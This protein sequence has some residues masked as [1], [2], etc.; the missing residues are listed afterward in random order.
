MSKSVLPKKLITS[1]PPSDNEQ[2]APSTLHERVTIN[3][4]FLRPMCSSSWKN[5]VLTSC[6][7][8]SDVRAANDNN[9]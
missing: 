9:A 1:Y 8:M 5:A 2:N 4:A 7:E 3:A 6:S